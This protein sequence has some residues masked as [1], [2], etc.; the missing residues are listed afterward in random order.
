MVKKWT[1][2]Y[3]RTDE[4]S[5]ERYVGVPETAH[6]QRGLERLD[7]WEASPVLTTH[8]ETDS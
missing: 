4:D 3:R 6:L 5:R 1:R 7:L 8:V 2:S